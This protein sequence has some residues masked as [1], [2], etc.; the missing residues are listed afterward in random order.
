MNVVW[1]SGFAPPVDARVA[2]ET[3]QQLYAEGRSS[4]RDLVDASRP[5][6]APMHACFE[7]NDNVAAERYREYQARNLINH[8]LVI[9]EPEENR[10]VT[11]AFFNIEQK[12]S[13]YEPLEFILSVP[14]KR[15]RLLEQARREM[16]SFIAKYRALKEMSVIIQAMERYIEETK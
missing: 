12:G 15:E 10:P 9:P 2:Y 16:Q 11:K 13:N 7:W 14:D 8:I 1:K 5:E 6:D 3:V 4:A